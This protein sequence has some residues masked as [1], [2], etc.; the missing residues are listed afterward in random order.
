MPGVPEAFLATFRPLPIPGYPPG[1]LCPQ[2]RGSFGV[3]R[4]GCK[5]QDC[6]SY[7]ACL[8][9][10]SIQIDKHSL[11]NSA[12]EK[13][14]DRRLSRYQDAR[15]QGLQPK[16]TEWKNIRA[17]FET[18]GETSAPAPRPPIEAVAA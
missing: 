12:V 5:M 18:G 15:H 9:A 6:A 11:L 14:K 13:D 7:A 10:A 16:N 4:T 8:R 3:C 2:I 1:F 17:A